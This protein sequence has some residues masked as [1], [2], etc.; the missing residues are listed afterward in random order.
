MRQTQ[1][2]KRHHHKPLPEQTVES[3][4]LTDE[5]LLDEATDVVLSHIDKAVGR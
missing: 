2:L 1:V 5:S 3:V 4:Q